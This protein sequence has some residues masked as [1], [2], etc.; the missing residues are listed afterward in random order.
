MWGHSEHNKRLKMLILLDKQQ[1][2]AEAFCQSQVHIMIFEVF[3]GGDCECNGGR[4]VDVLRRCMRAVESSGDPVTYVNALSTSFFHLLATTATSFL[5]LFT[6]DNNSANPSPSSPETAA[7]AA[8]VCMLLDWAH[9]QMNP[10][11][12]VISAQVLI[13]VLPTWIFCTVWIVYQ[14]SCSWGAMKPQH[15]CWWDWDISPN[16]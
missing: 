13:V 9:A 10:Y 14:C 16:Q 5:C 1:L 6:N 15:W 7:T 8:V 12:A 4:K 2:A 3:I 11:V